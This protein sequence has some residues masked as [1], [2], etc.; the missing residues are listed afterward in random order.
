[1]SRAP[2]RLALFRRQA[3]HAGS[4]V[5]VR[6][7]SSRAST[8]TATIAGDGRTV[9]RRK[10]KLHAGVNTVRLHGVPDG[11]YRFRLSAR[12]PGGKPVS[13]SARL[14]VR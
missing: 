14:T 5:R 9:A 4:P 12:V 8:G 6:V 11:T 3:A 13:R 10:V 2:L 1:V 7:M